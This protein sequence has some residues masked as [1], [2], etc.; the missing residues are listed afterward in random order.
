M[1]QHHLCCLLLINARSCYSI[2]L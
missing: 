1:T 2:I